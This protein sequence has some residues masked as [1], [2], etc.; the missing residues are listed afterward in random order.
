[1]L[2][3][4]SRTQV[5]IVAERPFLA[6]ARRLAS[7]TLVLAVAL[8]ADAPKGPADAPAAGASDQ[9][10]KREADRVALSNAEGGTV[11]RTTLKPD[12][13]AK[14]SASA[15]A[16][17]VPV[18]EPPIARAL[19]TM[20]ECKERFDKVK[21]YSC[22]FYK[23]ERIGGKLGS[24]HVMHMKVRNEP[25]SVYL[26]FQQPNRGREAIY[27]E[28]RNNGNVLA[29]DVGLT[30]FLAGTMEL[31]PRSAR[32]MQDCRHPITE[33]GIGSLI[34]TV[35]DRWT[36]E[37]KKSESVVLF[38]ADMRI[39]PA[40]C[41]MIEA[42]HPDRSPDYVFHKV[43][44]FINTDLGFPVR[45]EGYDWPKEEGGEAELMEEYAY[46]DLKLNV[47]LGD[48][49]FDVSNTLYSFGRF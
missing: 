42:I 16:A 1:M 5:G 45:F 4:P 2:P 22:T 33:A 32:A 14:S 34:R 41:L 24:L 30:K 3:K 31:E 38:D 19:R 8:A 48:Y 17:A 21:D 44:L 9:A 47:G 46:D 28:G 18:A 35:I 43:R 7:S 13:S 39:G 23:R 27:V 36:S 12:L 11:A 25:K 37:L 29:H 15:S 10:P 40:K 20:Q 49:D 26:K 6:S